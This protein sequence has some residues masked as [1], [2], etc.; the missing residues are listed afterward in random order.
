MGHIKKKVML[1]LSHNERFKELESNSLNLGWDAIATSTNW[2]KDACEKTT[3]GWDYTPHAA[4]RVGWY[5]YGHSIFNQFIGRRQF[6]SK[7]TGL[8]VGTL[9]HAHPLKGTSD[10]IQVMTALIQKYPGKFRMVGV[11]E[12]P[13]FQKTKPP[14]LNYIMEASRD[15]MANVMSQV[16]I[17]LVASY[18]EGLGRMTLEAMSAGCAIV[19]S[20]TQAEFLVDGTNCL[21]AMTDDV[22]GLTKCVEMLYEDTQLKEKLITAGLETATKAADPTDYIYNWNE[23]IGGLF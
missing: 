11:G 7:D 5:H 13:D 3:E 12:V 15:E 21:L 18:T 9:I 10:A 6:G 19:A 23:I 17:W 2:L 16:D 14:W 1:K 8:T 4:K 20:D 22:T